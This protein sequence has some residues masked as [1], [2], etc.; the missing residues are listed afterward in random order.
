MKRSRFT[1]RG[2]DRCPQ[3]DEGWAADA[4]RLSGELQGSAEGRVSECELVRE[5]G[6]G[7][8]TIE[9]WRKEYNAERPHSSL[10]YRTPKEFA[11]QCS[12]PT[13]G[14]AGQVE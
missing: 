3:A 8:G 9:A 5:S 11:R 13:S 1:S 6:Q 14:M 12:E 10:G 2:D 7:K 4:E